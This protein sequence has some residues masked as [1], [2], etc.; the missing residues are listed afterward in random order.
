MENSSNDSLGKPLDCEEQFLSCLI[1]FPNSLGQNL[2]EETTKKG[3]GSEYFENA[4]AR[5]GFDYLLEYYKLNPNLDKS[6]FRTWLHDNNKRINGAEADPYIDRLISLGPTTSGQ[7]NHFADAV[8]SRYQERGLQAMFR[9][10]SSKIHKSRE[11]PG[12]VKLYAEDLITQVYNLLPDDHRSCSFKQ[13]IIRAGA[14]VK[15]LLEKGPEKIP[16][17][18]TGFP[19]LDNKIGKLRPGQLVYIAANPSVGKTSLGVNITLNVVKNE[20]VP[21]LILSCEMTND[22]LARR[23]VYAEA[24]IDQHRVLRGLVTAEQNEEM[25][26][27]LDDRLPHVAKLGELISVEDS[28]V[29]EL[30]AILSLCRRMCQQKGVKLIVIDYVQLLNNRALRNSTRE[31]EVATISRSLKALARE[32]KV[33]I[34][35][36]SQLSRDNTRRSTSSGYN[37]PRLS[38]LRDS[39]ALEQ[40]ADIVIFIDRPVMSKDNCPGDEVDKAIIDVAKNR[41]GEIGKFWL[42]YEGKYTTFYDDIPENVREILMSRIGG[43]RVD[44]QYLINKH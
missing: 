42:R 17:L 9:E 11:E 39:G 18:S 44:P 1:K 31:N 22:E 12:M 27:R 40:D 36:M 38:D 8:K 5:V 25:I 41:G 23:V 26:K 29:N 19:S 15:E 30:S 4:E 33:P 43:N 14:S 16:G 20:K 6:T 28:G 3:I 2:I 13:T 10:F 37:I 24:E 35:A 32:L 21:V 7:Y 34:I